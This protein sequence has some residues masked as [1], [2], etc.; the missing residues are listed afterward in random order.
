MKK[1]FY[2]LHLILLATILAMSCENH[3]DNPGDFSV[4][5]NLEITPVLKSLHHGE[6]P[7][8]Q[9]RNIDST[10]RY[11]YIE[12][13]TLKDESGEPIIGEDG[14]LTI[15]EDTIYYNSKITARFT[16]YELVVLPWEMD[17]FE[18][19][20]KSNALWSANV[21]ITNSRTESTWYYNYNSTTTGGGDGSVFFRTKNNTSGRMRGIV[22]DQEIYSRDSTVMARL[23]FIQSFKPAE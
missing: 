4:K 7:L 23:H 15:T 20:F 13:D 5:C 14:N 12:D 11:F 16:E 17:T 19:S 6:I 18:I 8:T 22:A 1:L 21:P 9:V 2:L 10:Y 3:P